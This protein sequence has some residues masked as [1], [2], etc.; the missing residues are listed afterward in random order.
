MRFARWHAS[1]I[2]LAAS[3]LSAAIASALD[4]DGLTSVVAADEYDALHR[5]RT[6][7]P[8]LFLVDLEASGATEALRAIADESLAVSIIA[9]TPAD[10]SQATLR[11]LADGA[12]TCA[13]RSC[14]TAEL[15]ARVE[16]LLRRPPRSHPERARFIRI[17]DITIDPA[18]RS[19]WRAGDPLALAVSQFDVLLTLARGRGSVVPHARLIDACRWGHV[20]RPGLRVIIAD[21]RRL[22]GLR[23]RAVPRV[24]YALFRHTG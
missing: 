23:I 6:E 16:A 7:G 17:G 18:A 19:V 15:H 14:G 4:A 1:A 5:M 12:H 20:R 10:D 9:L 2:I 13:P 8:E 3:E 24:G 22:T 11:A 21:L